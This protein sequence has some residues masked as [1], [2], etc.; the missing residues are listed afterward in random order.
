MILSCDENGFSLRF[1]GR[2][3]LRHSKEEPML[4]AGVGQESVTM[5]RGNFTILDEVTE[6]IALR[7]FSVSQADGEAH[8]HFSS[9][10]ADLSYDMDIRVIN[11]R[12]HLTGSC[13]QGRFNRLWLSLHA[14][15]REH[16]YGLGEQ[17]SSLDLRGRSYPIITSEQGVGRNKKTMTT[18]LA[19]QFDGGGGDYW[20]TYFPQASL[21]SSRLYFFNLSGYDYAVIDLKNRDHHGIHIWSASFSAFIGAQESY[22]RLLEELT[23]I[24]GRQPMLPAW[25]FRGVWLGVQGGSDLCRRKVQR[26]LDAGTDVSAVWTQDW[27]GRRDTSFGQRLQWDWR[28]NRGLYPTLEEDIREFQSRGIYWLGYIN[29]YLVSGGMLFEEARKSGFFVRRRDGS[30]YLMDFGEFDCGFIDLTNPAAFLWYRDII[31]N[32]MLKIGLM[33]W[34]ADFGEYLPTDCVLHSGISPVKAHNQW[35]TLWAKLNREA[36]EAAGLGTQAAF[37]TRSGA[38]HTGRYSPM[39][40]GG[41]QCVDWSEDDGLPSVINA[42]LSLSLS[43]FGLFTFDIG[44]YTALFGMHRTKELLLRGCEFAAFT[45]VMR[46]HEGNRPA[47][48][49][50]F[51]QDEETIAFFSRFSRIHTCLGDYIISLA[52][53]NSLRGVPVMRPLFF[54]SPEDEKAAVA[55]YQYLLGEDMLVAP[56]VRQGAVTRRLYLPAGRWLHLWSAQAYQGGQDVEVASPLG[57]PPVFLREGSRVAG[58]MDTLR[59]IR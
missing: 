1:K 2:L 29:P 44:G 45:P 30:D 17:F 36:V 34:M 35:P 51:D 14:Q 31:I 57:Q 48:N 13:S 37:F 32:N 11:G 5:R 39:M 22:P 49:H 20:T 38:S 42:A 27:A 3:L 12:L 41:D 46:T 58:L 26:M 54:H 43:G 40:F 33:G 52:Q 18:F 25:A 6:R 59:A 55:M 9:D 47:L 16:V 23:D 8:I 53:E 24:L 7:G 50:Q 56:V 10:C 4:Y 28:W 19:D 15:E 21:I